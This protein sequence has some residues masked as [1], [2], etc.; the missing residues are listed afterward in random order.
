MSEYR[1]EATVAR[2]NEIGVSACRRLGGMSEYRSEATVARSNEIG[3]SASV[4]PD[5]VH[6]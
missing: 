6:R 1:S 2:S 4:H 5:R 3:V